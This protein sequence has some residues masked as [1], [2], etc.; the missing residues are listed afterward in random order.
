MVGSVCL[1]IQM[2]VPAYCISQFN[3]V[4]TYR[5]SDFLEMSRFTI[6]E[7][8]KIINLVASNDSSVLALM[9]EDKAI[10]IYKNM[11]KT[12]EFMDMIDLSSDEELLGLSKCLVF[13]KNSNTSIYFVDQC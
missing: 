12:F 13:D 10:Y 8:S 4:V 6:E 9:T 11:G 1:S 3:T 7:D 5:Q 2:K